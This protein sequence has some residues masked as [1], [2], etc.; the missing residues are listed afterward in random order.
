V[1]GGDKGWRAL[2]MLGVTIVALPKPI[3]IL[4]D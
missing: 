4:R 2:N 1:R 3:E